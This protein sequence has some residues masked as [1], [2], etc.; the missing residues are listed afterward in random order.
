MENK[1]FFKKY[2]A[3]IL[4]AIAFTLLNIWYF[5]VTVADMGL[6]VQFIAVKT[7]HLLQLNLEKKMVI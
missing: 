7:G 3:Y 4:T 6:V 2:E 1:S 5:N